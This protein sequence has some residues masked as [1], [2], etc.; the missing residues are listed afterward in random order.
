LTWFL[1]NKKTPTEIVCTLPIIKSFS[2]YHE[3]EKRK[4]E[5]QGGRDL[6]R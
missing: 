2:V 1:E 5:K 3:D 6:K 4:G